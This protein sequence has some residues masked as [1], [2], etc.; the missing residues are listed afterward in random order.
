MPSSDQSA[1]G[2]TGAS[3]SGMKMDHDGKAFTVSSV[4]MVSSSCDINK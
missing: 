4:D 2:S 1:S 3:S